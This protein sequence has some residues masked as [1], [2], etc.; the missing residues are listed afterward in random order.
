MNSIGEPLHDRYCHTGGFVIAAV[1]LAALL[2]GVGELLVAQWPEVS[3]R[4]LDRAALMAV[5]AAGCSWAMTYGHLDAEAPTLV[6]LSRGLLAGAMVVLT[7]IDWRVHRLPDL[8][9]LPTF[10]ASAALVVLGGGPV[11]HAFVGAAVYFVVLATIYFVKPAA[12]GFGDAKLALSLG[13]TLGWLDVR[14]VLYALTI[15]SFFGVAVGLVQI[16]RKRPGA[17]A[18]GPALCAGTVVAVAFS[19]NILSSLS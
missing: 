13:L 2:G 12:M 10:L 15:A 8:V 1:I 3:R 6:C 14:L 11:V 7:V 16:A 9:T 19:S 17:F 4:R 5:A 18:F